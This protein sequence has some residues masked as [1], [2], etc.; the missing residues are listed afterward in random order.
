MHT[1]CIGILSIVLN[2]DCI[3]AW[4][5]GGVAGVR[6][7]PTG[8]GVSP[9]PRARYRRDNPCSDPIRTAVRQAQ[10]ND[11]TRPAS[12]LCVIEFIITQLS[13]LIRDVYL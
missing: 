9:V 10:A 7:G 1:A 2:L 3:D 13:F 8:W 6:Q 11:V 4:D 5:S 12:H